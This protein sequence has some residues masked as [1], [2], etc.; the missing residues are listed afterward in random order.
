MFMHINNNFNNQ[1]YFL[2]VVNKFNSDEK[3]SIINELNNL[4]VKRIIKY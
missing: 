1:Q 2:E 4:K 3:E